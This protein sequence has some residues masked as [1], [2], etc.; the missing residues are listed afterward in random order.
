MVP[1]GRCWLIPACSSSLRVHKPAD[2]ARYLIK[3]Q[4]EVGGTGLDGSFGHAFELGGLRVFDDYG[5]PRDFTAE[6][7][8]APS[9]PVPVRTQAMARGPCVPATDSN[10]RSAEGR[11]K[12]TSG[13]LDSVSV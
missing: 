8:I 9:L 6:R 5:P 11:T 1:R 7:P 12:W 3:W 4:Y 2:H 13:L 10:S